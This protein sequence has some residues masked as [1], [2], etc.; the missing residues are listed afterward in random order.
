M[1]IHCLLPLL[2]RYVGCCR[3]A[4]CCCCCCCWYCHCNCNCNSSNA[5]NFLIAADE[6]A[7]AS[8]GGGAAKNLICNQDRAQ[9]TVHK[10]CFLKGKVTT[11][12]HN[13]VVKQ[14]QQRRVKRELFS[15]GREQILF[16]QPI[17]SIF[18]FFCIYARKYCLWENKKKNRDYIRKIIKYTYASSSIGLADQ[19]VQVQACESVRRSRARAEM[20]LLCQL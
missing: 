13:V 18:S 10:N 12:G 14:Q 9:I 4:W 3:A 19:L 16:H 2:V 11:S 5:C 20:R 1:I 8:G 6:E 15:M 7:A 17:C